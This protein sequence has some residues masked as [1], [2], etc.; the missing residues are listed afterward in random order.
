MGPRIRPVVG[1]DTGPAAK[2][3]NVR[4]EKLGLPPHGAHF[5]RDYGGVKCSV[6][7][8]DFK[9]RQCRQDFADVI[10]AWEAEQAAPK[11]A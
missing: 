9:R 6:L 11:A 1:Q 7:G 2:H 5:G 10:D 8:L 3:R 4:K